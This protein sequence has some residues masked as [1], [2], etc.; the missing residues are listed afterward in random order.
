MRYSA[1]IIMYKATLFMQEYELNCILL[2]T[3]L[4][5]ISGR[6]TLGRNK[7]AKLTQADWMGSSKK[8]NKQIEIVEKDVLPVNGFF[9]MSCITCFQ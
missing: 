1:N 6:V 5:Y 8:R 3:Q 9:G 7:L 4:K 2:L